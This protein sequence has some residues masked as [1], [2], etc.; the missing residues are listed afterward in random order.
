MST[1]TE[2]VRL[3]NTIEVASLAIL[4]DGSGAFTGTV[5][6]NGAIKKVA[7]LIGTLAA[8]SDFTLSD[9]VTLENVH[10]KSSAAN[11]AAYP[12]IQNVD[13]ADSGISGQY[14]EPVVGTAK[15][16]VAQGGAAGAGTLYIYYTRL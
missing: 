11:Y 7:V 15:L 1:Y 10:V 2:T 3:H 14:A 13:S 12:K 8:T 9:N 16:V 5:A 4:C 6:V